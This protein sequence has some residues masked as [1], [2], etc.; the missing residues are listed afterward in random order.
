[1]QKSLGGNTVVPITLEHYKLMH[2]CCVHEMTKHV[3]KI[4]H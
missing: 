2:T 1:M 3:Y 4:S